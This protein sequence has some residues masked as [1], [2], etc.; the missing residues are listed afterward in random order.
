MGRVPLRL[1]TRA[2]LTLVPG[3][4]QEKTAKREAAE[5]AKKIR[6]RQKAEKA[7][8][9][10]LAKAEVELKPEYKQALATKKVIDFIQQLKKDAAKAYFNAIAQ[11]GT[12]K[13]T[14]PELMDFA[15]QLGPNAAGAYFDAIREH[16]TKKLVTKEVM[17][18]TQQLGKN[19]WMYFYA[20]ARQ[21]TEKLASKEFLTPEVAKFA[22]QL[23]EDAAGAYFNAIAQHG[24]EKLTTKEIMNFAQQLPTHTA[25]QYFYAIARHGTKKLASKEVMTQ[26]VAK[27]TQQLPEDAAGAYFNAIAQHGPEK[28]TSK[29]FMD[30][31]KQLPP[32]TAWHYF[33]AIVV[34]G[35][36]KLAS[37]EFMTH[38]VAK[39]TQ[40]L[41]TNTARQY[42]NAIT[43]HGTKRLTSTEVM[44]QEVAKFTQQLPPVTARQY[45]K[46]IAQHGTKK[47]AS[48]EVMD[49]AFRAVKPKAMEAFFNAVGHEESLSE[50][51][52]LLKRIHEARSENSISEEEAQTHILHAIATAGLAD[53]LKIN[54]ALGT[55]IDTLISTA[56][57]ITKSKLKDNPDFRNFLAHGMRKR[58]FVTS[59]PNLIREINRIHELNP[60][61]GLIEK[62]AEEA[63][64][65][66]TLNK[67]AEAKKLLNQINQIRKKLT[68]AD[69]KAEESTLQEKIAKIEEQ[70]AVE[71]TIQNLK[72][73]IPK[74]ETK[75]R[76]T[77]N[78]TIE[79]A[80]TRQDLK[81]ALKKYTERTQTPEKTKRDM[82]RIIE[83]TPTPSITT[84]QIQHPEK[85]QKELKEL[86]QSITQTTNWTKQELQE[87][88]KKGY[89]PTT[90][91]NTIHNTYLTESTKE[92]AK[93]FPTL[94]EQ[95]LKQILTQ[96][97]E[98][99]EKTDD[100][101]NPQLIE[102]IADY[103]TRD[104]THSN[105]K[106][107]QDYWIAYMQGY[108]Q[109]GTTKALEEYKKIKY[110][111]HPELPP[112]W[113]QDT[114][115]TGLDAPTTTTEVK[116]KRNAILQELKSAKK[117]PLENLTPEEQTKITETL[118]KISKQL[119]T[120]PEQKIEAHREQI[121][122]AAQEALKKL[123]TIPNAAIITDYINNIMRIIDEGKNTLRTDTYLT[124]D[125]R[126]TTMYA[127]KI[128]DT[129]CNNINNL[130]SEHTKARARII[131]DARSR[132]LYVGTSENE[133]LSRTIINNW[134]VNNT[135][136]IVVQSFYGLTRESLM[137]IIITELLELAER[138]KQPLNILQETQKGSNKQYLEDP[139]VQEI[140]RQKG[141]TIKETTVT[142]TIPESKFG[143][144][145]L[146]T[147]FQ[148]MDQGT[149][150]QKVYRITPPKKTGAIKPK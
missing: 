115:K 25:R 43:L 128:S 146:D 148:T 18:F 100:L 110:Q 111:E 52:P 120:L 42:F 9:N 50:I 83:A 99:Q 21:G 123:D 2:E 118:Q 28:L 103:A 140:L 122:N 54:H 11:H 47:L 70:L 82:T 46:A 64:L 48:K 130:G 113:Q 135:P 119:S 72:A 33:D 143:P 98:Q 84:E 14:T 81:N 91:I 76:E 39:F 102:F 1:N 139:R 127:D 147:G 55:N 86:E 29:E 138:C 75:Q 44:T 95:Q 32:D 149:I 10:L 126:L 93:A 62:I 65:A 71:Q 88:L 131:H 96:I 15:K 24:P 94:P 49:L 108:A 145:Y 51:E 89:D 144:T 74:T 92:I 129:S 137:P 104:I 23:P 57:L 27:F 125:P 26:E 67:H 97:A 58:N 36:E 56:Q 61:Q 38:E 124:D 107:Q 142:I 68:P 19:T 4:A 20:I 112:A 7:L 45:F 66:Q 101:A 8:D 132:I 13:L 116:N 16:G 63:H 90:T 3:R 37:K 6:E 59:T 78:Q 30:F 53:I 105:T 114:I 34:H 136:E 41:P 12:E 133:F 87:K 60:T 117:E 150:T 40:Q 22:Q 106:E 85:T 73:L 17:D 77:F 80:K 121:S 35:P 5:T 31:A 141:F 134:P 109:G 69:L 79:K